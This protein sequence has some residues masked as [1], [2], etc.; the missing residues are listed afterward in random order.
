M[1]MVSDISAESRTEGVRVEKQRHYFLLRAFSRALFTSSRIVNPPMCR[2]G[3]F[4]SGSVTI[5]AV[6]GKL[7]C[8]L[9]M[10]SDNASFFIETPAGFRVTYH[11]EP[12]GALRLTA[13]YS[14]TSSLPMVV[15]EISSSGRPTRVSSMNLAIVGLSFSGSNV[16]NGFGNAHSK[17]HS[18]HF[19]SICFLTPVGNSCQSSIG[20]VRALMT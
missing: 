7:W 15:V 6:H 20:A 2:I 4:V 13:A 1:P 14:M 12:H 10:A 19:C 16:Q 5:V 17:P 3:S 18:L 8:A 11:V 9:A